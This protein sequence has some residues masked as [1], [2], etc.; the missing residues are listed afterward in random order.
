[1]RAYAYNPIYIVGCLT[2]LKKYIDSIFGDLI[3]IER[4]IKAF[5]LINDLMQSITYLAHLSLS[6]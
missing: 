2:N 1:M 4:K 3:T 6:P 5:L